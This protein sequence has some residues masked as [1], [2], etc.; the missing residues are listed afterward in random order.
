[1]TSQ[2][3]ENINL[4]LRRDEV[5]HRLRQL[6]CGDWSPTADASPRAYEIYCQTQ[7]NYF[8]QGKRNFDN[9][10]HE[11]L[12]LLRMFREDDAKENIMIQLKSLPQ[13]GQKPLSEESCHHMIDF[14][15]GLITP[16][17]IG[18][19][20]N[21]VKDRRHLQWTSGTLRRL[22]A[23]YFN[24]PPVLTFEHLKLPKAF[25]A[26]SLCKV[27]GIKIRFTDNLADHLLLIDDD[28]T[29]LVFHHVSY[30]RQQDTEYVDTTQLLTP[31]A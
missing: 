28:T 24:D 16:I 7:W 9:H 10:A 14:V 21:E 2:V 17:N 29:L 11:I 25:D 6:A 23:D 12:E 22:V 8:A 31:Q 4:P 20:P 27:G 18:T 1:M 15:A 5:G 26:W 13:A 3:L 19:R 30:L